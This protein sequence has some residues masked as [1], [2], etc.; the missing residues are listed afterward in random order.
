M[1]T[2]LLKIWHQLRFLYQISPKVLI[3]RLAQKIIAPI[4]QHEVGYISLRNESDFSL[5]KYKDSKDTECI[6]LNTTESLQIWENKISTLIPVKE[7]K[8]YL[9]DEPGSIVIFATRP[10]SNGSEKKVIGYR[11]CQQGVFTAPGINGKLSPDT[12]FVLY[13]EVLPEYRGQRVNRIMMDTTQEFCQQNGLKKLIGVILSHNQPSIKHSMR[14]KGTRIIG[15]VELLSL[16]SGLYKRA[17]SW[18]EIKKTID[19]S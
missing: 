19:E 11:M 6:V 7:L 1:S 3:R 9:A 10:V 18:D 15:R 8:R 12:L 17:T 4:Y 16:F 2:K 13:T 5:A 14:W